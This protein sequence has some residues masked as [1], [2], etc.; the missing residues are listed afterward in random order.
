MRITECAERL[1]KLDAEIER[2]LVQSEPAAVA[3]PAPRKDHPDPAVVAEAR[4]VLRGLW[5]AAGLL[6]V[7]PLPAAPV[8]RVQAAIGVALRKL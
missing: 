8:R 3:A 4:T 6:T 2:L 7:S 5:L 1:A